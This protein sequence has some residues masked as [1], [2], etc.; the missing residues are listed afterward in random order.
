[1]Q[2][3]GLTK[4]ITPHTLRHS[5][6]THLLQSGADI[7][8]VQA[9]LGHSDVKTTQIYTH[10]LQQGA[11]CVVSPFN[12]I[13]RK[14]ALAEHSLCRIEQIALNDLNHLLI[15]QSNHQ[16]IYPNFFRRRNELRL[17]ASSWHFLATRNHKTLV[18]IGLVFNCVGWRLAYPTYI[19]IN[20]PVV[21][22]SL[23]PVLAHIY[24][25]I[26]KTNPFR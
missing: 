20:L 14:N 1:M 15:A 25:I 7:R 12:I 9:Q 26:F 16:R 21:V 4:I 19:G 23:P 10:V 22:L 24:F 2:K 6:A 13:R 3:S 8:T 17:I 11:N 5:F 18:I